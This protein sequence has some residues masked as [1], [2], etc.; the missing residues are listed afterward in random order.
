MLYYVIS[1]FEHLD[2]C[3]FQLIKTTHSFLN[4]TEIYYH[5]VLVYL[6]T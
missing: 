5:L 3:V 1:V 2:S 4:N 6:K